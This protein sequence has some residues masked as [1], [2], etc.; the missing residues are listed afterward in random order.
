MWP[1][2]PQYIWARQVQGWKERD[3]RHLKYIESVVPNQEQSPRPWPHLYNPST[4]W[5]PASYMESI[6]IYCCYPGLGGGC[7]QYYLQ[8]IWNHIWWK[9]WKDAN[10]FQGGE[11]PAE[12]ISSCFN[13]NII[14]S[15]PIFVQDKWTLLKLNAWKNIPSSTESPRSLKRV[16]REITSMIGPIFN[17]TLGTILI[18]ILEIGSLLLLGNYVP[19]VRK[20]GRPPPPRKWSTR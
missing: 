3:V 5:P 9:K 10:L 6:L 15:F 17:K 7:M 11:C 4:W 18:S 19:T 20:I 12:C 8:D 14:Y 16:T 2:G 1:P 13:N